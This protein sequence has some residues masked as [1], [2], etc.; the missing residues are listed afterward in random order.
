[1]DFVMDANVLGEV[2][3]NNKKAIELIK[4]IKNHRVIYCIEIFKEYRALPEKRFCKN[5]KLIKEWLIGLVTKSGHGKKVKIDETINLCFRRLIERKKFKK[6]DIVY[7][8]T[9][10]KSND[11]LLIAFE[12]H[13]R[14]ADKCISELNIKRLEIEK[15]LDMMGSS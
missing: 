13:F 1:M 4:R 8:N 7:I 6:K 11:N 14:N 10:Q 15:A 9:V 12:L 2:C 5:S 3:R